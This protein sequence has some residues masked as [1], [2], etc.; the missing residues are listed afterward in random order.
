MSGYYDDK[1]AA[2]RLR[3]CYE[4][5]SPR[6]R[7]YLRAEIGYVARKV[8]RG[9][10][11]LELG[12]GYGRVLGPWTARAR[13]VV[14]V[15]TSLASLALAREELASCDNVRLVQGDAVRLGLCDGAVDVVA[16][17]QNGI[18]AFHVDPRELMAEAVRVARPGGRVLFSSYA[19]AFWEE[20]LAWFEAQAAAGLLGAIDYARTGGGVIACKDG[21]EATTFASRDFEALAAS[22]G[23]EASLSEVDDSSLFCEIVKPI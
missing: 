18:S 3:R 23:L 6:V 15:D 2:E 1:L 10:V 12:C 7:Q 21:F 17:I 9:D 4:L 11:V 22:L 20:R 19:E 5:A 16:C 14:G 13:L 8:G